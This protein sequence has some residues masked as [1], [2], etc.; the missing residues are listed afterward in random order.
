M[1]TIELLK[2]S[3]EDFV[4]FQQNYGQLQEEHSGE[5]VAVRDKQVIDSDSD[6]FGL[7]GK[8][9]DKSIDTAKVLIKKVLSAKEVLVYHA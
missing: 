4:W 5:Y 1:E 9:K 6:Y 2:K 3:K 8:L 7:L